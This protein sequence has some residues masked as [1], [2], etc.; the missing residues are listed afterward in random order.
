MER[1]FCMPAIQRFGSC[2]LH[3]GSALF[4]SSL[5]WKLGMFFPSS[6]LSGHAAPSLWIMSVFLFLHLRGHCFLSDLGSCLSMVPA[7]RVAPLWIPHLP[8]THCSWIKYSPPQFP[9]LIMKGQRTE[10]WRLNTLGEIY[11]WEQGPS[12]GYFEELSSE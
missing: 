8:T 3:L 9:V 12:A 2:T 11:K 10:T 7:F 4:L 6:R 5:P 1:L